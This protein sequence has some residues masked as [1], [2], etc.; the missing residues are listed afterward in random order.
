MMRQKRKQACKYNKRWS[1]YIS[2]CIC[3]STFQFNMFQVKA[4]GDVNVNELVKTEHSPTS[5]I[6]ITK[7]PVTLYP[8]SID[9]KTVYLTFDDGPSEYTEK[10]LALL[11]EYNAKATFFMLEPNMR[12]HPKVL[13]NIIKNGHQPA[14][15]GVSHKVEIIYISPQTVIDEMIQANATL[16][17]ITGVDSNLVRTPFGSSPFMDASYH[18]AVAE[19]GFHLWDW[20]VDSEDWRYRQGQYVNRIIKQMN[21]LSYKHKPMVV[22]LHEKKSTIKHLRP[23]LEYLQREGYK[24]EVLDKH[25]LPLQFEIK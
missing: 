1:L 16:K 14:L 22:L 12:K 9:D 3:L 17:K 2:F 8:A 15:H 24:M 21:T 6:S 10:L 13:K 18:R 19:A 25:F 11:K 4:E 5:F 23:L 7:I 20:T